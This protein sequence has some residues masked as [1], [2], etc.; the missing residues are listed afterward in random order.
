MRVNPS[1]IESDFCFH[2]ASFFLIFKMISSQV[3]SFLGLAPN[4]MPRYTKSNCIRLQFS[5]LENFHIF[6]S[7][8]PIPSKLFLWKSTFKP[9]TSSKHPRI[10][11]IHI[12]PL[13]LTSKKNKVSC[14]LQHRDL[15]IFFL[16][17]YPVW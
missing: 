8:T 7:S 1:P 5:K 17:L 6:P 15:Y 3:A 12:M 16:T 14:K 11:F 9:K 10:V 4:G 2:I 13:V